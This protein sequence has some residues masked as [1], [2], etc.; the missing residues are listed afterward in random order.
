[1]P[2]CLPVVPSPSSPERARLEP[3]WQKGKPVDSSRNKAFA[4]E[5]RDPPL[6]ASLQNWQNKI[7]PN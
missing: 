2:V 3:I 4:L 6:P 5:Q 7:A 1:M